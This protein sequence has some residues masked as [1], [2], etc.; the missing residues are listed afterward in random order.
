MSEV[1]YCGAGIADIT[2]T[3]ENG[4]LPIPAG[5]S[6]HRKALTCV[7]DETKVR[8]IALKKGDTRVLVISLDIVNMEADY[9][10]PII[11]EHT[12]YREEEIFFLESTAHSTVRAGNDS[13]NRGNREGLEK[14][15]KYRDIV[16]DR[17]IEAVDH[18][19]ASMQPAKVSTGYASSY[20]NVNRDYR[21]YAYENGQRKD[22]YMTGMNLDGDSDH[23]LSVLKFA[24]YDEK[25]IAILLT[26][27]MFNV[28]MDQN[29][30]GEDGTGAVS[31]DI[32]GYVSKRLEEH[33][34]GSVAIWATSSGCNQDPI[35]KARPAVKDPDLGGRS[36]RHLSRETTLEL[37]SLLGDMNY[38]D[39]V[40]AIDS[41]TTWQEVDSLSFTMGEIEVPAVKKQVI[42]EDPESEFAVFRYVNNGIRHVRLV[43]LKINNIAV[44]FYGGNIY[45]SIGKYMKQECIADE[46]LIVTGFV[47]SK[48]KFEGALID[49]DALAKGGH[50]A[51]MRQFRAGFVK[52]AVALLMNKLIYQLQ[53]DDYYCETTGWSRKA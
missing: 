18:A 16:K 20:I 22:F 32:S 21:Y 35:M 4:I 19:I 51:D 38:G 43:V 47:S 30:C 49:D 12:G 42:R 7:A 40:E 48:I 29:V 52:N 37:L 13:K 33:Y 39:A 45:S 46:S 10:G 1:F 31:S 17:M 3:V 44:M 36:I 15:L 6:A 5:Y 41:N 50:D 8:V 53:G 2:P 27:S 9:Y 14:V 23:Q 26:F 24:D 11:A 25:P 28:F 34:P